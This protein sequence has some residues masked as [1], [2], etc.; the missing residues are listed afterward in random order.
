MM[1]E[2]AVRLARLVEALGLPVHALHEAPQDP[3]RSARAGR[4]TEAWLRSLQ[5]RPGDVG[6]GQRHP[7][8]WPARTTLD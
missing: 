2:R 5:H 3:R 8:H 1:T 6:V 7:L 4:A